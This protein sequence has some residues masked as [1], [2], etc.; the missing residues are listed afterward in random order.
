MRAE[1]AERPAACLVGVEA[2]G[3]ERRVVA[4]VLQIAAAEVADLAELARVDQLAREPHRRNETIVEG[5]QML[6]AGRSDRLPDLVALVGVA[7]E[8]LLADDVLSRLRC[9]DRRLPVDGVR[10][11]VV[12]QGDTGVGDEVV[13]VGRPALVAVPLGGGSHGLLVPAGNRDQPGTERRRPGHVGDLP[14]RVRVRLAHEGVPEHADADL[15]DV[16]GRGFG[17]VSRQRAHERCIAA[18]KATADGAKSVRR[19]NASASCAPY[20][21][22]IPESSHSMDSGP[23]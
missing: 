18:S 21:R 10:P 7:P 19:T 1:I 17:P 23:V 15:R 13:P 2:P 14:E 12:E 22:S 11:A 6:H 8:R 4:P 3:V 9:G 16:A 5:A 20:S